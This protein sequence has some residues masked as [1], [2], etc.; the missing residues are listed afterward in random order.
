MAKTGILTLTLVLMAATW[1]ASSAQTSSTCTNVL[2]SMSP[3][4]NYIT[5]NTSTPSSGCCSQLSSVVKSQPECLCQVISG[6]GSSAAA[7]SMGINVNRTQAL[8]LPT[9]CKVQTPSISRC[10]GAVFVVEFEAASPSSDSPASDNSGTSS[11]PTT[12]T[13]TGSKESPSVDTS[14]GHEIKTELS[15]FLTLLL[16]LFFVASSAQ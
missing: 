5:G 4:L 6:S 10:T 9:A 8:E 14:K 7:A 12:M 3:C 11:T 16:A 15:V 2:I 1:T 13:S